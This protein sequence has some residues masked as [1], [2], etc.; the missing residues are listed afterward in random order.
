MKNDNGKFTDVTSQT[1]PFLK[2]LGMVC[3]AAV[4][5]FDKDGWAD[6]ALVGEWMPITILKNKKGTF[7]ENIKDD[8]EGWWNSIEAADVNKDGFPDFIMGNEGL[9]SF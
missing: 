6:I 5:D 8:T 7:E 4:G 2:G 9:N 1:A 3:D